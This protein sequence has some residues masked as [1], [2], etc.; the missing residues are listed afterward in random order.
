LWDGLLELD[1]LKVVSVLPNS[2]LEDIVP[3]VDEKIVC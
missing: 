3:Y 2:V 1:I